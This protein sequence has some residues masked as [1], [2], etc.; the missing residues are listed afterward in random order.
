MKCNE[1]LQE[2]LERLKNIDTKEYNGNSD[3]HAFHAGQIVTLEEL[4]PL[5]DRMQA[6]ID[7][8]RNK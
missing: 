8:C 4:I 7:N 1:T 5:L 2:R 6:D 3:E